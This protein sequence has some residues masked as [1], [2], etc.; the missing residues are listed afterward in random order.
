LV[1]YFEH[2]SCPTSGRTDESVEKVRQVIQEERWL[3]INGVCNVLSFCVQDQAKNDR[4]FLP[5]VI[6]TFPFPKDEHPVTGTK[7]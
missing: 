7:I 4:N 2:F 3:M 1:E 5:E 6:V